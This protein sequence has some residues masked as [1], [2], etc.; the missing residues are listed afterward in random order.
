[1][2]LKKYSIIDII[3]ICLLLCFLIYGFITFFYELLYLQLVYYP[4]ILTELSHSDLTLI[5]IH[6][7]LMDFRLILT[8]MF[9]Y[10][11]LKIEKLL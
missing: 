5:N 11:V 4:S 3:L 10:S 2:K 9:I 8:A 1:M 6:L 7:A